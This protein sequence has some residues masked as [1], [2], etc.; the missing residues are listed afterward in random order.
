MTAVDKLLVALVL[1]AMGA[2][3]ALLGND[4]RQPGAWVALAAEIY[5]LWAITRPTDGGGPTAP[6]G[7]TDDV[8]ACMLA[9]A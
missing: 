4:P 3:V 8:V 1:L 9:S 2:T 5:T 7:A 6:V